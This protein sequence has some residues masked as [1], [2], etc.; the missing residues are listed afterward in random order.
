MPL[1]GLL[2]SWPLASLLGRLTHSII[3]VS[4]PSAN[5][6]HFPHLF[7]S[8]IIFSIFSMVK[9][10]PFRLPL[11]YAVVKKKSQNPILRRMCSLLLG[12]REWTSCLI[13]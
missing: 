5:V 6:S 9:L 7:R 11:C 2:R 13:L 12:R 4:E 10:V 3:K 1:R 8:N